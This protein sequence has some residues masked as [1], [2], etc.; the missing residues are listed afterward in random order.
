MCRFLDVFVEVEL[1]ST[2]FR[3]LI[4]D[5]YNHFGLVLVDYLHPPGNC[6][7]PIWVSPL[8][9]LAAIYNTAGIPTHRYR[10]QVFYH[11]IEQSMWNKVY[12][13]L[14]C[15]RSRYHDIFILRAHDIAK[16]YFGEGTP[17]VGDIEMNQSMLIHNL[18]PLLY[19]LRPN[20]AVIVEMG[21]MHIKPVKPLPEVSTTNTML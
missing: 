18:N 11:S 14:W 5:K 9:V 8:G 2:G 10:T 15:L 6:K 4:N 7:A 17:Y 13:V 1:N 3:E 16:K 21:Q 12:S 19:P 20:V